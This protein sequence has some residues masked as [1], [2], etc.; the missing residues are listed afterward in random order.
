MCGRYAQGF[1]VRAI[2][3]QLERGEM[4]IDDI[5]DLDNHYPSYNVAPTNFQPVYRRERSEQ[6]DQNHELTSEAERET[7]T[8][9]DVDMTAG[10]TEAHPP[11]HDSR[12]NTT[13]KICHVLQGMKWGLVPFWTKRPP[14]AQNQLKTINC[15]DD[16]LIENR[17]MW[18]SMKGRKRCIIPIQGY[19][20]WLKKGPKEKIPHFTKRKDG[21]MMM[22]AGLYDC[23]Q[24]EG[25][26]ERLWSYTIITTAASTE[27]A[28]LHDRMPL[29]LDQGSDEMK[30]WL[31]DDAWSQDLI[32]LL[33]PYEGG[34]DCYPVKKEVGKVGHS[35]PDYIIPIDS[36]ENKSNIANFFQKQTGAS[37]KAEKEETK[38]RIKEEAIDTNDRAMDNQQEENN[39]PMPDVHG[40]REVPDEVKV[41]IYPK[42]E[43][44][45]TLREADLPFRFIPSHLETRPLETIDVYIATIHANLTSRVIALINSYLKIPNEDLSHL[46]RIKSSRK[47]A[48]D[49]PLK[50]IKLEE[51]IEAAPIQMEIL[52]CS[53]ASRSEA[54]LTAILAE[55][56]LDLSP[57]VAQVSKFP[58]L[59][60]QQFKE[61][62]TLWPL[63]WRVPAQRRV[64]MSRQEFEEC[65][66]LMCSTL[67]SAS[68]MAT[69]PD[70]PITA[71]A[72]DP[73]QKREIARSSD[74]RRS[75]EQPLK[76]AI[77]ELVAAVAAHET[78][79]RIDN[80]E[81]TAQY[82]CSNLYIFVTHEPCTMCC[83]A[84]LHS[85]VSHVFYAQKM[86]LTGGFESNYGIHW[87]SD[88][89]HRFIVFG[90][91]M[92]E[93][94]HYIDENTY[95]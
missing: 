64:K 13:G 68:L 70:L 5:R 75:H 72:W 36:V 51:G 16:S 74:S 25:S 12:K 20:E 76:H 59:T 23:V 62:G 87:R 95:V 3:E 79:R 10:Q 66:K 7:D 39:A 37:P 89:N 35:S 80:P 9:A 50:K 93:R 8:S 92:Q 83:M 2:A 11:G 60:Q 81:S 67:D 54:D 30:R 22:L 90:G 14:E 82:L 18:N 49:A 41:P 34:L 88:L 27:L 71:I 69:S 57:R 40:A 65:E 38:Q 44:G 42:E 15:R 4:G 78:I 94:A 32:K 55:A 63:S 52:L 77:I 61:W 53:C 73:V 56:D 91:W 84:L 21:Q 47:E 28:W 29:I 43:K 58:P 86:D 48:E 31:D 1:A 6:Y 33:K 45:E 85:R 17:G 19:Y 26:P 46:K 24:Y